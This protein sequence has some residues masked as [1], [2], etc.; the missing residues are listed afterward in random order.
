MNID[1]PNPNL[2]DVEIREDFLSKIY[3]ARCSFDY[4]FTCSGPEGQ[5]ADF[6]MWK[7]P[8]TAREMIDFTTCK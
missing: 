4:K 3:I 6:N 8:L 1:Y 2:E 5:V 7:R